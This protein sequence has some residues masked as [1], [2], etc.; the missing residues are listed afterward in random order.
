MHLRA[1][2]GVET[3]DVL[4]KELKGKALIV[5]WDEGPTKKRDPDEP[6]FSPEESLDELEALCTSLGLEIKGRVLQQWRPD[7]KGRL[8]IG[9]GK[10][11]ELRNLVETDPEIGTIVFD[12]DLNYRSLM[13]L[14][15]RIAPNNEAVMLDRTALIL[16]IF[17]SRARTPEAKLQVQLAETEFMMP[18]LRFYL[19]EGAGLESK[20]GSAGGGPGMKGMGQTQI[21]QDKY[22]LRKQIK[23]VKDKLAEVRKHRDNMRE[24]QTSRGIPIVSLVGYT[25][26]GKSSLMNRIRG[27][28][29]VKAKDRLFETLDTTHKM[30]KLSTGREVLLVDTV[31]FVQ[32][33]PTELVDGFRATLEE[34]SDAD[35]VVHVVDISASTAAQ[36][37]GNVMGTLKQIKGYDIET[38][39]ILAFNKCDKLEGG[40]SPELEQTLEFPWPGVKCH[41][42]ISALTGM[43]MPALADAIEDTLQKYT[44]YGSSKM[45]IL[46]PY[47]EGKLYGKIRNRWVM[48]NKEEH[49]A[50]GYLLDITADPSAAVQ[51]KKWEQKEEA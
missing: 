11:E 31:G 18:R 12:K 29:V 28:A 24:E 2:E 15:G 34:L 10:M 23:R 6:P 37:I 17:A 22:M 1:G 27:E 44:K 42:Q 38:P 49:T 25:N 48:V 20:G 45:K 47:T 7:R 21:V 41:C 43:G 19:T 14:K 40:L 50:D 16:R 39:Q 35:V 26:A 32:R 51:L 9:K 3:S 5:G 46:I 8:P 33:L 30:V 4:G 36:Q 13:S